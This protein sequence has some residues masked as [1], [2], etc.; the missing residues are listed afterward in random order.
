MGECGRV[1]GCGWCGEGIW[2]WGEVDEEGG[3]EVYGGECGNEERKE[4]GRDGK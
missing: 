4:D 2:R 3:E 1:G